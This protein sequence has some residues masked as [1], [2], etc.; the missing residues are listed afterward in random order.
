MDLQV[1]CLLFLYAQYA[2]AVS[3]LLLSVQTTLV[4][5][6]MSS[7]A[8]S[9]E[10]T[11]VESTAETQDTQKSRLG[12]FDQTVKITKWLT[13]YS[14][15]KLPEVCQNIEIGRSGTLTT[16]CVDTE[17]D[18]NPVIRA[19]ESYLFIHLFP[20]A[21]TTTSTVDE[22]ST[23]TSSVLEAAT[24]TS[25]IIETSTAVAVTT[26]NANATATTTVA[27]TSMASSTSSRTTETSTPTASP[28]PTAD[29]AAEQKGKLMAEY[30]ISN[31]D[32]WATD[33]GDEFQSKVSDCGI[34]TGWNWQKHDGNGS[35]VKFILPRTME[36][37]VKGAISSA[38]G[39]QISCKTKT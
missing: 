2:Q 16:V 38:G 19:I 33:G 4:S 13:V 8:V 36:E 3:S 7:S 34:V 18:T 35:S 26:A 5:R 11:V 29:C 28:T 23:S 27:Q 24:A 30:H 10:A 31:I 14:Q 39:P 22:T 37:C 12:M 32:A 15:E 1:L 25:S 21:S 6:A 17:D 20:S 9:P